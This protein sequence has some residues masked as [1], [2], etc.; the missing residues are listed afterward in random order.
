MQSKDKEQRMK[1]FLKEVDK[2]LQMKGEPFLYRE[3]FSEGMECCEAMS[4]N[5]G[6]AQKIL[7]LLS[8]LLKNVTPF[9]K[10]R[11]IIDYDPQKTMR[12]QFFRDPKAPE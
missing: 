6:T 5:N 7:I 11:I 9:R 1:D 3:G 4:L 8:Q 12:F 10:M 2:L